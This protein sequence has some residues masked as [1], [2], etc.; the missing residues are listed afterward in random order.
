MR[1]GLPASRSRSACR[2]RRL[3]GQEPGQPRQRI[4]KSPAPSALDPA[5]GMLLKRLVNFCVLGPLEVR[6][7]GRSVQLA[8]PKQRALLALLLLARGRPV[9]VDRL[10]DGLWGDEAPARAVKTVQVYVGQL[11]KAL[12]EDVLVT[13]GSAYAIPLAGHVL[14]AD[15]FD[16]LSGEGRRLLDDG[17]AKR[18]AETLREALAL[19]RG[20]ALADF[21]YEE[22]A[23]AEIAR[24]EEE[25]LA[26][27]G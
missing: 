27:L 26:V 11:R 22:F 10:A 2:H 5:P 13:H 6:D 18:A 3:G 12:G 4:G 20:P 15:R 8:A 24:L 14:D 9:S 16:R 17:A 1:G 25:R 19:W 21:A 23:Q 7:G